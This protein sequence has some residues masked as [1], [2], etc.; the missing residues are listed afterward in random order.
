[1]N[2]P[3]KQ[4]IVPPSFVPALMTTLPLSRLKGFGGKLGHQLKGDFGITLAGQLSALGEAALS[5]R[6]ELTQCKWMIAAARGELDEPVT[7]RTVHEVVSCGKT[8]RGATG[9]SLA[10]FFS[11]SAHQQTPALPSTGSVVFRWLKELC[12]ELIGRLASLAND[13][14]RIAKQGAVSFSIAQPANPAFQPLRLTRSFPLPVKYDVD[15]L[16]QIVHSHVKQCLTRSSLSAVVI[17]ACR[18][19][20]LFVCG[21]SFETR[22]SERHAINRYFSAP[23]ASQVS[24]PPEENTPKATAP[25]KETRPVESEAK[26][27]ESCGPS[28]PDDIDLEVFNSLPEALQSELRLF[29]QTQSDTLER[30]RPS[31]SLS[32]SGHGRDKKKRAEG[33]SKYFAKLT[34][35]IR[36]FNL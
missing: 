31:P 32:T 17:P 36:F 34:I 4:T 9:L 29:Y 7:P 16:S 11:T 18:I 10:E 13:H 6:Y 21:N 26:D 23:K 1:M 15:S 20:A 25:V 28:L 33:I 3:N 35:S 30:K 5:T 14:S 2:K 27:E 22:A 24:R 19:T 12:D 8:F